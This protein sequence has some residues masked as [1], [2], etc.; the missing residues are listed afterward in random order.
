MSVKKKKNKKNP[1]LLRDCYVL[2]GFNFC[3]AFGR[4]GKKSTSKDHRYF[5]K[6]LSGIKFSRDHVTAGRL[7]GN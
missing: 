3:K 2:I 4:E 1:N 6:G 5:G 7:G